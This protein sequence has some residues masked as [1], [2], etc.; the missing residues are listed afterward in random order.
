MSAQRLA[1]SSDAIRNLLLA[2][3]AGRPISPFREFVLALIRGARRPL[4]L[5]IDDGAPSCDLLC[6]ERLV[7]A[8]I[9]GDARLVDARL[10]WLV[11]PDR[12][13]RVRTALYAAAERLWEAGL[14]PQ[15]VEAHEAAG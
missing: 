15:M 8:A 3:A 7:K 14:A 6:T 5:F 10:L 1:A 9:E 2:V 13:D 4:R 12:R 11:R